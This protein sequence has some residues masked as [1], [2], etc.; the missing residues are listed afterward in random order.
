MKA[1]RSLTLA[2]VSGLALTFGAQSASAQTTSRDEEVIGAIF[3][4]IFGD[5]FGASGSLD[6]QWSIGRRPLFDQRSQF[7]ARVQADVRAGRLSS[8]AGDRLRQDYAALVEVETRYAADR[9]F[10]AQERA[11]L[12]ARY[13]AL[14][15][16]LESGGYD[17][18]GPGLSIAQGRAEFDARV[19]AQV[20]A[21][22]LSRTDGTRLKSDYAALIRVE[23]EYLADGRLST[24]ERDDL[25][26]RLDALDVRVGD[27][28][29]GGG[30]TPMTPRQRLDAVARALPASGLSATAQTQLRVEHED[31]LRLEAA[32]AQLR[33]SADDQAYLERRIVDLETRVRLRR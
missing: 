20:R 33:V 14:T 3:G 22:R 21:R 1:A 18:G 24:R 9:R 4:A 10:T 26:T 2:A 23:A 30:A 17:D 13:N 6:Q 5:R 16:A 11:D 12:T 8:W 27:V 15:Q 7:D 29:Y 28:G 25:E 19:D 32:Y 31:L